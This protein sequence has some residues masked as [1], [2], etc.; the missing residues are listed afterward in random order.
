MTLSRYAVVQLAREK[1]S[2][3]L[4][5]R[6]LDRIADALERLADEAE[7][8]EVRRAAKGLLKLQTNHAVEP[9]RRPLRVV[10]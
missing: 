10:K 6:A 8:A 7:R 9:E 2:D 1:G 4:D 5:G 3:R